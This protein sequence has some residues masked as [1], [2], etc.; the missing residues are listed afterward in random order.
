MLVLM[1]TRAGKTP[2][3]DIRCVIPSRARTGALEQL[4]EAIT[5]REQGAVRGQAAL[6][7]REAALQDGEDELK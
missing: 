3:S 5:A 7:E 6:L 2:I 4:E 1:I